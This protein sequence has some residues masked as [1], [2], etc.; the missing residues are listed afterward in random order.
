MYRDCCCTSK[1]WYWMDEFGNSLETPS[2]EL[3]LDQEDFNK[4]LK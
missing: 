1:V 4:L 3:Q 2:A